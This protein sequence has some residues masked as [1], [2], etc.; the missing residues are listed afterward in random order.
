MPKANPL[1]P[2]TTDAAKTMAQKAAKVP[3]VILFSP[4]YK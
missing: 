3:I 1:I 4:Y 2:C